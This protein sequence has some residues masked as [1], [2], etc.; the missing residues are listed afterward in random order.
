MN[1]L[2]RYEE[3]WLWA[4]RGAQR[5]TFHHGDLELTCAVT[6]QDR[7][8]FRGLKAGV[9]LSRNNDLAW[10]R[11]W[12]RFH[13]R[14]HGLEAMLFFDNGSDLYGLE[15]IEDVLAGV[16]GLKTFR[17]VSA[18][19][20]FGPMGRKPH[21][22]RSNFLQPALLNLAR[23]RFLSRAKAVLQADIDELFVPKNDQ[24]VFDA[25]LAS[26][27]GYALFDGSWRYAPRI[28]GDRPRHADHVFHD[29]QSA[30]PETKYCIRPKSLFGHIHWEVHGVVKG[31]MK[32]RF[33]HPGIRYLHCAQ[34]S[35]NWK[36]VRGI[37]H[38]ERLER[39]PMAEALMA[40]MFP[41]PAPQGAP[42]ISAAV[43][44][45]DR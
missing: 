9:T 25:A 41:A 22:F 43:N 1:R 39:D 15:D 16:R 7:E 27:F 34:I 13:V 44:A 20:P 14:Q 23:I 32:K 28:A 10:I 35:T 8:T 17:V 2:R 29:P 19:H 40:E 5:L 36:A 12:V 6:G 33:I 38:P 30:R 24:T 31:F 4:P 42:A 45:P 11:D 3:V 21:A 37:P 18:P 26:P